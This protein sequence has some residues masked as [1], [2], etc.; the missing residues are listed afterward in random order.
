MGVVG[1]VDGNR[2]VVDE[3]KSVGKSTLEGRDY[4]DRVDGALKL[5]QGLGEDFAGWLCTRQK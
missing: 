3:G 2:D 5:G 4:D 1:S